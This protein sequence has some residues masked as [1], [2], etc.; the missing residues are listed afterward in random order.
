MKFRKKLL[1]ILISL[2]ILSSFAVTAVY[3]DTKDEIIT[4]TIEFVTMESSYDTGGKILEDLSEAEAAMKA[5]AEQLEREIYVTGL[6]VNKD[7]VAQFYYNFIFENP[8]YFYLFS[9]LSYK[10]NPAD[11]S[12][13]SIHPKYIT[14]EKNP[15]QDTAEEIAQQ[16]AEIQ[17]M[18]ALFDK[19][20]EKLMECIDDSMSE[21]DKL[22]ALHD[23]LVCH[24][25]YTDVPDGKYSKSVFTAYGAIAEGKGV[26]QSYTLAYEY[27][28]KLAGI[29]DI[30][31]VSNSYHSWNMV[32]LNGNWYHIDATFDDP[33]NDVL[34][35]VSHKYFLIS[36]AKLRSNDSSQN[37]STWSPDYKAESTIYDESNNFWNKT[38][39]QIVFDNGKTYYVDM[40]SKDS[41]SNNVGIIKELGSD[42][43]EKDLARITDY[44]KAP[45]GS[46]YIGNFTR[47]FKAGDCL[48]YNTS[49][50]V[51]KV[52]LSDG[53]SETVYTLAD[54][55]KASNCIYGLKKGDNIIY[56]G[57]SPTPNNVATVIEYEYNFQESTE[58]QYKKGDVD[59]S[60]QV[61]IYDATYLQKFLAEIVES[62]DMELADMNG[63]NRISIVDCTLIQMVLAG[64]YEV[65]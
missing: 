22:L 54:D 20:T 17:E 39:S 11:N 49:D 42:G 32:K 18:K 41:N 33:I 21:T 43:T 9:G 4:E 3:A 6:G 44:W 16:N 24:V 47:I 19:N 14:S 48:Y 55:L 52:N 45:G 7:N 29:N 65:N 15:G 27:L 37:H 51:I 5:G 50:S 8:Q 28:A 23:A 10:F 40:S 26:C 53:K 34:G 36:D 2:C 56:I 46:Y 35:R 12:V 1:S 64:T 63:D 38:E 59:K 61:N 58:P 13:I 57:Y 31:F 30:Y 25:S 62:V 60:G